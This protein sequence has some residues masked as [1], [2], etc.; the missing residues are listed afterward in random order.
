MKPTGEALIE[1]PFHDVDMM[2]VAW[3]GHYYKYF[4][5]ARTALFR[6]FHCDADDLRAMGLTLPVIQTQCR[7][8]APLAYGVTAR[9]AA[10]L[11]ESEF[12]L[13]V[14]YVIADLATG[15]RLAKGRTVQVVVRVRDAQLLF[16]VPEQI[17][18]RFAPI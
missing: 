10:T 8:L 15:R 13:G 2:G 16:P 17:I 5:L 14:E 3:H 1:V 6:K 11:V 4:E 18:R 9:V 12:R 7:Y